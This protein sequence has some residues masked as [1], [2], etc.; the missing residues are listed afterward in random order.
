MD[1]SKGISRD[2]MERNTL[3]QYSVELG[4]RTHRPS[5]VTPTFEPVRSSISS[6]SNFSTSPQHGAENNWWALP[7][8]QTAN[9]EQRN[10]K[11]NIAYSRIEIYEKANVSVVAGSKQEKL[12][13]RDLK[14]PKRETP[15]CDN[16][17][18]SSPASDLMNKQDSLNDVT[19]PTRGNYKQPSAAGMEYF[20]YASNRY[21]N[22]TTSQSNSHYKSTHDA[23]AP[24][25]GHN[26]D[27][28]FCTFE[29]ARRSYPSSESDDDDDVSL[30]HYGIDSENSLQDKLLCEMA[31]QETTLLTGRHGDDNAAEHSPSTEEHLQVL[32][33]HFS[34]DREPVECLSLPAYPKVSEGSISLSHTS[35]A[36]QTQCIAITLQSPVTY[37]TEE[38]MS[39]ESSTM[40]YR[41]L[42]LNDGHEQAT[43]EA[44]DNLSDD[45][46]H[47]EPVA[48][49]DGTKCFHNSEIP[50]V[51]EIDPIK[52][53]S[54]VS[55]YGRWLYISSR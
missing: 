30:I 33:D 34:M 26:R 43:P 19:N 1:K 17:W 41:E 55:Q 3:R 47:V 12:S 29:E 54:S 49:D 8:S 13:S 46:T 39:A 48:V 36:S 7:R 40:N 10:K 35:G 4:L 22:S 11:V 24:S 20:L 16:F 6:I 9:Y 27:M 53:E 21:Q 38:I 28:K 2:K 5:A 15:V 32:S 37:G 51:R 18:C 42:S 50:T 25:K 14:S 31:K 52:N 45:V 23:E 44:V